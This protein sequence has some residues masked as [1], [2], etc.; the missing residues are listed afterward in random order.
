VHATLVDSA[1]VSYERFV[2][3]LSPTVKERYYQEMKR[4]AVML[5]VPAD[6]LPASFDEFSDYVARTVDQLDVTDDAR[7]LARGVLHPQKPRYFR[8]VSVWLATLTTALLPPRIRD[9]YDLRLTPAKKQAF[10]A[11]SWMLRRLVPVL[12]DRFRRWP[13]A[14]AAERRAR[15][16]G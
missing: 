15:S 9:A 6:I 5:E 14:R 4:Q 11:S 12:P 13:H 2:G 8:P 3:P 7:R 10:E 1:L 16:A